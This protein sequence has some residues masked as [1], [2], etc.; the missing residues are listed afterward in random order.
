MFFE[1]I[2]LFISILLLLILSGFFSGS[3]TALTASTRSRLTGLSNKGHKNAKTAIELLNK[4]E[5]L[6]GA[7]LLGNNLVNILASAL[8]TSLSIKIFGDTGVAYAVIIMTA[9]IVIFAEI[10]PKTYALTNSEKLA[11]TVSPIFKPIVYLLWPVTWMMEK[12]VFFILSIFKIKLEKN[13]RVLSVEDEIRGTLDL[14]HKEGRLYKSDKDMVTGVL[15]LAEVTVED[16]M[17][18]RSNMFTVNIDDDPKKILNSVINSSFT[19]I[20][21]WQ[22]NDENII[23]IIHSKHLLK[24]MS[25]NRDITRLDMMQSLIKPLFIPETTS[26]KEQL[27][28]HLNTKKKLAIVVD[29]YGVLMGMISLEDIMEEIVGDITDEIDEGLTS[30]VKNEDGTLTINGGTEIRDINRIY[31][32]DLPEEEANTLSGLIIHESRSFPSEGQVFN[33]YGFIF[34]IL[35]VRDNLIHKIKVSSFN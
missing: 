17:V 2:I 19:R 8:A 22:N 14:H 34:E 4:K 15:D 33:Y 23:G 32:W 1:L 30:V 28:M 13:M 6:I 20:P 5:S 11:L 9:L 31:N 3:E 12:I 27:K 10:L 18:H 25:Q 21:V 35:E 26:L 24:I 7:I 29:E 16:V